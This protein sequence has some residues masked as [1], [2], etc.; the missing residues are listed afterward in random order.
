MKFKSNE[1]DRSPRP[2]L[3]DFPS[4][5]HTR[6]G[7]LT[8]K[9]VVAHLRVFI[10]KEEM[11][12]ALACRLTL[13]L[14]GEGRGVKALEQLLSLALLASFSCFAFAYVLTE[15]LINGREPN[16]KGLGLPCPKAGSG[17]CFSA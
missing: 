3:D 5:S 17:M 1:A 13:S 7:T 8:M 6:T 9:A 2:F 14:S 15:L 4:L 12:V 11:G 10:K 16:W